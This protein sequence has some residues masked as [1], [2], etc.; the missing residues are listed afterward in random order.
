[1]SLAVTLLVTR[2]RGEPVNGRLTNS[3]I[4]RGPRSGLL[5]LRRDFAHR[6]DASVRRDIVVALKPCVEILQN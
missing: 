2:I 3:L 5:R 4:R 1:M 6:V